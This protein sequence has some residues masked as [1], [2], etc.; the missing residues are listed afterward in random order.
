MFEANVAR[1]GSS[2]RT[3]AFVFDASTV[4]QMISNVASVTIDCSM[5]LAKE[6]VDR[7]TIWTDAKVLRASITGNVI[8]VIASVARNH[9]VAVALVCWRT[10][11]AE[12]IVLLTLLIFV[13][14]VVVAA[15]TNQ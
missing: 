5:S 4:I 14:V 2:I 3:I 9:V 11:G 8:T 13:V 1:Y 10:V 7:G 15:F 6:A 12:T